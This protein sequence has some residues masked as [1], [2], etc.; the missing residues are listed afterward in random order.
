MQS[1]R[2]D[3]THVELL[4]I[5]AQC[6][7]MLLPLTDLFVMRSGKPAPVQAPKAFK[8]GAALSAFALLIT[9]F[10]LAKKWLGVGLCCGNFLLRVSEAA[11]VLQL[12]CRATSTATVKPLL[13]PIE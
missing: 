9:M 10:A 13:R 12:H 7:F 8:M 2:M 5:V 6:L 4:L 3:I 11:R 1:G